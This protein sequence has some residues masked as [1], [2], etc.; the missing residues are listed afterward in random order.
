MK[1]PVVILSE[2]S[3]KNGSARDQAIPILA[4]V[5]KCEEDNI[6]YRIMSGGKPF[7]ANF[8]QLH[9]GF[10]HSG[11]LLAIY[12]G[13]EQTG[14]DIELVKK[15]KNIE[16]I[17]KSHFFS[18]TEQNDFDLFSSQ[19]K[20]SSDDSVK[21]DFFYRL[22]TEKEARVK[23]DGLSVFDFKAAQKEKG[24]I[25]SWQLSLKSD[26][27]SNR[28]IIC[29]NSL[30]WKVADSVSFKFYNNSNMFV[31]VKTLGILLLL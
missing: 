6:S 22:W 2:Y 13:K 27:I 7:L 4:K 31:S 23:R 15:R 5:L 24:F 25:K 20:D 11:S 26:L 8:P 29:L 28:Y 1:L 18:M 17:V 14:I 30:S 10:S 9:I 16:K 21:L 12:L 19:Y 3:R